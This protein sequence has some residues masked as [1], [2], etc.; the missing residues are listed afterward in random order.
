MSE[1]DPELLDPPV[2]EPAP[3]APVVRS[4]STDL[5]AL[6][7]DAGGRA[8]TIEEIESLLQGRGFAMFI[9]L[10]SAPF[11]VPAPGLSTP[12]GIAIAVL[13]LRI[14]LGQKPSLP[15]F[16]LRR[17]IKYSVLEGVI[18]RLAR[19][20]EK[21]ERHIKP[22]MHYLERPL[23]INL[24]GVG[25]VSSAFILALPVPIPF[26]NGLPAVSIMLLAAGMME[27]DGLLVIW[28]HIFGLLSWIY[29]AFWWKAV[30]MLV[31]GVRH[32]FAP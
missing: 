28:G 17:K 30:V 13:G 31:V 19:I 6:L 10:L 21:L 1:R 11:L 2:E 7:R 20:V 12:F 25:I 27:R 23:M 32:Y 18:T 5:R 8:V 29:L 26:S 4:L 14:A 9:L 16:I 24:I 3:P 15:P 22:R